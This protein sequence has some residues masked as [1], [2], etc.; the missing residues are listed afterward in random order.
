MVE[1]LIRANDVT[2]RDEIKELR[3]CYKKGYVVVIK[4]AGHRWGKEE[5][6]K[7]KFYILRVKDA[8]SEDLAH[9]LNPH[10]IVIGSRYHATL[11]RLGVFVSSPDK[12]TAQTECLKRCQLIIQELSHFGVGE[13]ECNI[14]VEE[15]PEV[16]MVA[17]RR[18]K[19]DLSDIE[20]SLKEG[21]VE[22]SMKDLKI[23]DQRQ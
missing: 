16:Y 14:K 1:L 6:N 9:L 2:H 12:D 22:M 11:D 20:D 3:G 13:V 7:E 17:R 4:P 23:I 19:L 15:E 18:Y 5:L 21:I 10:E 8:E